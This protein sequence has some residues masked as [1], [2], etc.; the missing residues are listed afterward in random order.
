MCV[1]RINLKKD[2]FKAEWK[3]WINVMQK[4]VF[5]NMF[6]KN[7]LFHRAFIIYFPSFSISFERNSFSGS[8]RSH[9]NIV[10]C[11]FTHKWRNECLFY[12]FLRRFFLPFFFV[13]ELTLLIFTFLRFVDVDQSAM[14]QLHLKLKLET[15]SP[16]RPHKFNDG[17]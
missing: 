4:H 6:N 2:E 7:E 15:H 9:N 14:L 13:S 5:W 3:E 8:Q 1:Y 17:I 12:T 11:P 16:S 10:S